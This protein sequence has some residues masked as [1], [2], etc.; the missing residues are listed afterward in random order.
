IQIGPNGQL[1]PFNS[2]ADDENGKFL[3][4]LRGNANLNR[5][6]NK[7]R[8]ENS[9]MLKLIQPSKGD[10]RELVKDL[11]VFI[12]WMT[13]QKEAQQGL[14][15]LQDLLV[16]GGMLDFRRFAETG[17]IAVPYQRKKRDNAQSLLLLIFRH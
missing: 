5:F 14:F 16:A 3:L 8:A 10:A 13:G 11:L 2:I 17:C 4:R 9:L 15:F 6:D 1:L 12:H 7:G